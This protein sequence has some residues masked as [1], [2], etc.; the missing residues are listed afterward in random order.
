VLRV[1]LRLTLSISAPVTRLWSLSSSLDSLPFSSGRA[2]AC[3]AAVAHDALQRRGG[4]EFLAQTVAFAAC[5]AGA[6]VGFK[7]QPAAQRGTVLQV[8]PAA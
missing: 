3:A 1:S 8:Q 7:P 5:R 6:A 4:V 2:V